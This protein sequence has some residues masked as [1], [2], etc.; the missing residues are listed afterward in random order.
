MFHGV[1]VYV[2]ILSR[3][4]AKALFSLELIFLITVHKT[5]RNP[6]LISVST[7]TPHQ[8]CE[9]PGNYPVFIV[10]MVIYTSIWRIMHYY[11][12]PDFF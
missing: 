1:G 9:L 4:E 5:Q 8:R 12:T 6:L 2:F 3:V 10:I 11:L 7:S